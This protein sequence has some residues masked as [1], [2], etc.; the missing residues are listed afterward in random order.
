MRRLQALQPQLKKIQNKYKS[1]K[2]PASREA[3]SRETMKVYQDNHA[4]P[5]GSCLPSLLQAPVFFSLYNLLRNIG[6]IAAGKVTTGAGG[7]T[8]PIGA[9]TK[10]IAQQIENTHFFS[11]KLS[12]IFSTTPDV[13]SRIIIGVFVGVMCL[14]MWY[15]Q[16]HS[17]RNNTPRATME[18]AQY[19]MQKI[20]PYIFPAFY[21]LSGWQ[22]PFGVLFYWVTNNLWTLGQSLL[23]VRYM[24]TPGSPAAER[25]EVRDHKKENARRARAG[26]LSLE[27]EELQ[28]A[29]LDVEAKQKGSFQRAQPSKKKRKVN[30]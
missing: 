26:E 11:V 20:M 17:V 16:F 8:D 1:K 29:R 10:P 9:F 18:G 3:M 15:M 22:M 25:K 28:K 21:L 5:M 6:N 27:E 23:Q 2:D 14:T 19:R 7:S 30:K 4:N 24:P 12:D 13:S